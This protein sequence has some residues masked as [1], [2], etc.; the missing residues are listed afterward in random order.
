MRN[1]LSRIIT[2][3]MACIFTVVTLC[4]ASYNPT[5][6]NPSLL[7]DNA[8]KPFIDLFGP[9]GG[10]DP[11]VDPSDDAEDSDFGEDNPDY[12]SPND[13]TSEDNKNHYDNEDE[14]FDEDDPSS[15][16][17]LIESEEIIIIVEWDK[18][19][20]KD[21]QDVDVE[22]ILQRIDDT[23]KQ[24]TIIDNYAEAGTYRIIMSKLQDLGF[25]NIVEEKD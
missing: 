7:N 18:Y 21:Y 9:G 16:Q 25:S 14:D 23:S 11:I 20:F 2:I 8:S 6:W 5:K 17:Q 24:I 13:D 22:D 10:F 12:A 19:Y 4:G 15:E 3:G 1:R